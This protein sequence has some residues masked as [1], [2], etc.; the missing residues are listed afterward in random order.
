VNGHSNDVRG[1]ITRYL[2]AFTGST[3]AP[4]VWL[5]TDNT[6]DHAVMQPLYF[7]V[8]DAQGQPVTAPA[9]NDALLF[10]VIRADI[11]QRD[12]SLKA[13]FALF[14]QDSEHLLSSVTTDGPEEAWPE[15]SGG[16]VELRCAL[17]QRLLN[18]GIYRLE[19][20]CSLHNRE[21]I[22]RPGHNS[23]A[24]Q[25]EIQGGL[26]ES[27]YWRHRRPGLLAPVWKW[28]RGK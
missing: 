22:V 13:G 16:E 15:L 19:L 6:F 2:G 14:N 4:S 28:E 11:R 25:F 20:H 10:V 7:A 1:L 18:E 9:R 26:S 5:N 3:S 12:P 8:E 17:P 27:P 23:P 21:W 24:V